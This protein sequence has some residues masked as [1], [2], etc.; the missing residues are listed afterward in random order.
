MPDFW[1]QA[2]IAAKFLL[3]LG[4]L[5]SVGLVLCRQVFSDQLL[6]IDRF[7]RVW[8][9]IFALLAMA[10]S[11]FGFAVQGA[12]LMDDASGMIDP[13]ILALLWETPPGTA[14][15]L[16]V[17]G[18]GALLVGTVLG[19]RWL[20]VALLGGVVAIWSFSEIGHVASENRLWFE[21]VLF[22]HLI[23]A[24]FW[25]GVLLPLQRL[26]GPGNTMN[27]AAILGHRFGQAASVAVPLLL[28]AGVVMTWRLV[29]SVPALIGSAYGLTLLT[30]IAVVTALLALA[31]IN[32]TRLVPALQ[33]GDAKAGARLARSITV[34][35][36]CIGLILLATAVFTSILQVPS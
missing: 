35:W 26:S 30:K 34:E 31:A 22:L 5:T 12:V 17:L 13:A 14:L 11:L 16:R 36:I 21:A 19:G 18:L 20:W 33:R 27:G 8:A 9:V 28:L 10:T 3:Y 15:L 1:G 7:V 24:A 6:G 29:G 2:A 4:V 32:K 23:V 25:I